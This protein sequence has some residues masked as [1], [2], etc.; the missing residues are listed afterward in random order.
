LHLS[1]KSYRSHSPPSGAPAF[2]SPHKRFTDRGFFICSQILLGFRTV[3]KENFRFI[4][5]NR[6][7]AIQPSRVWVFYAAKKVEI[8]ENS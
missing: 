1:L 4:I 7:S 3:E 2:D 6:K 5:G 8:L